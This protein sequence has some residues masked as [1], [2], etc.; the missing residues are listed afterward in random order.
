M[1]HLSAVL[2]ISL[3]FQ[4]GQLKHKP[5]D[6]IWWLIKILNDLAW[7]EVHY[8]LHRVS[9]KF[10]LFS[11]AN[12]RSNINYLQLRTFA[13]K[14]LIPFLQYPVYVWIYTRDIL[15]AFNTAA[16]FAVMPVSIAVFSKVCSVPTVSNVYSEI[17]WQVFVCS[18]TLKKWQIFH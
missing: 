1:G 16:S 8:W 15:Y 3:A 5:S 2:D 4:K 11:F 17:P 13:N 14:W 10:N 6:Y 18:I 7:K 12:T 9:K